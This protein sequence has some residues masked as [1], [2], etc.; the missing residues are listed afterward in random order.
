MR[1]TNQRIDVDRDQLMLAVGIQFRK[2]PVRAEPGI[3]DQH[4]DRTS[5][6]PHREGIDARPG[7]QVPDDHF[8]VNPGSAMANSLRHRV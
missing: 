6:E 1:E 7:A 2:P 8:D 4:L 5:L 3:I